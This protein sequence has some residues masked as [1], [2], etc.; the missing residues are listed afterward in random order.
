M[1]SDLE[2]KPKWLTG[3]MTKSTFCHVMSSVQLL[4]ALMFR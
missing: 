2:K 1:F 3:I 4:W